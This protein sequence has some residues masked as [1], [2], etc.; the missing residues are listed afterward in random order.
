MWHRVAL[1][2][3]DVS[4]NAPNSLILFTLMMEAI[5]SSETSVLTVAT[6]RH[7]PGGGILH[8]HRRVNLKS[9]IRLW[10]GS[11]L[12]RIL[13]G[14]RHPWLRASFTVSPS[15]WQYFKLGATTSLHTLSWALLTNRRLD[16]LTS[17]RDFSGCSTRPALKADNFTAICEWIV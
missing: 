5:R 3:N 2:R 15:G 9:Y 6:R 12:A 11:C 13:T 17:T 7:I 1:V 16:L 8:S 10:F 14:I 4:S